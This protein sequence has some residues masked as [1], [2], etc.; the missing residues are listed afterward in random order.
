[1]W[2]ITLESRWAALAILYIDAPISGGAARA[3][4]GEMTMMSAG[5]SWIFENRMARALAADY[6]PLSS[7]DIFVKD[8]G[9]VI[10]MARASKFS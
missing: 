5:D 6:T 4:S 3:A 1:M 8:L 2:F 9:L 10:D 7:V